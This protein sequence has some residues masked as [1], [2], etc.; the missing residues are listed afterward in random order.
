MLCYC[1]LLYHILSND[2]TLRSDHGKIEK[3]TVEYLGRK[4][5]RRIAQG[6]G[7]IVWASGRKSL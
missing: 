3:N 6:K 7:R 2:I 4:N 1:K 5:V